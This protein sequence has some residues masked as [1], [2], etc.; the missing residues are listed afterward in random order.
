MARCRMIR[1]EFFT[2]GALY[3]AEIACGYPVRLAYAGLWCVADREGRFVWRPRELKLAILPFDSCDFEQVLMALVTAGFIEC[4]E[5]DGSRYG[6]VTTFSRHQK[7]HPR[8]APSRFPPP[9]TTKAVKRHDQ[10]SAKVVPSPSESELE[11]VSKEESV[12]E[13]ESEGVQAPT[14]LPRSPFPALGPNGSESPEEKRDRIKAG[15]AAWKRGSATPG[16]PEGGLV[17]TAQ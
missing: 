9:P 2:H 14:D 5:V 6:L 7:P 8:E 11:S 3:D 12:T 16:N 17:E 10:G 15:V 4:Y 13:S 1:P